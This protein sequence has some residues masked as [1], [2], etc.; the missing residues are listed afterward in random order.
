M[1]T[2]NVE[3]FLLTFERTA[4]QQKWLK[5]LWATQVAGLLSGKAMTAYAALTPE[6]TAVYDRVNDERLTASKSPGLL[7]IQIEPYESGGVISRICKLLWGPFNS[8]GCQ[9]IK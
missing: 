4:A 8:I 6:D 1:P 2:D 9:S 7:M 3:H 5:K